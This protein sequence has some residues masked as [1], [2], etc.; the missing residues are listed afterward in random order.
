MVWSDK[1]V[2]IMTVHIFFLQN[3]NYQF[4]RK[5][6]LQQLDNGNSNIKAAL[7]IYIKVCSL[8]ENPNVQTHTRIPIWRVMIWVLVTWVSVISFKSGAYAIFCCRTTFFVAGLLLT[9]F[10]CKQK[11]GTLDILQWHI[12]RF[13]LQC[14][15]VIKQRHLIWML[16]FSTPLLNVNKNVAHWTFFSGIWMFFTSMWWSNKTETFDMNVIIFIIFHI[17]LNKTIDICEF[18]SWLKLRPWLNSMTQTQIITQQ[19][20]TLNWYWSHIFPNS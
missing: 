17:F 11:C 4:S 20:Y 6:S 13:L 19:K 14:D 1:G 7:I 18:E 8:N 3:P 15:E 9:S 16:L 5:T 2:L 12:G 10:K